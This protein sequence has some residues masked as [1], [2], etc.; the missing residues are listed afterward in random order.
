M[1]IRLS[2]AALN[3]NRELAWYVSQPP[4]DV[5]LP[6]VIA[7]GGGRSCSLKL[8][9]LLNHTLKWIC[10]PNHT[11]K[12]TLFK[13]CYTRHP[14][15]LFNVSVCSTLCSV[16]CECMS[17]HTYTCAHHGGLVYFCS[18]AVTHCQ[19]VSCTREVLSGL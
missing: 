10:P 6:V 19:L 17:T 7:A 4:T 3:Y 15:I 9:R 18:Q 5:L 13:V 2:S 16:V 12:P 8:T 14:L 1:C 11:H